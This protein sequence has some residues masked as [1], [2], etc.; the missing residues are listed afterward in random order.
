MRLAAASRFPKKRGPATSSKC[1]V[2]VWGP[3]PRSARGTSTNLVR[4]IALAVPTFS[5]AGLAAARSDF[6]AGLPARLAH[7]LCKLL[8]LRSVR[9]PLPE[10]TFPM[11]LTWHARSQADPGSRYFRDLIGE[12]L[13]AAPL[14]AGPRNRKKA[15]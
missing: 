14:A 13:R 3:T 4:N 15:R 7:I 6:V 5:A 8:P 12:T 2:R 10:H 11:C 9:T 1:A